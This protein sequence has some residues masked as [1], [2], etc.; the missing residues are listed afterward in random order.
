MSE[1]KASVLE[2]KEIKD[3]VPHPRQDKAPPQ[4]LIIKTKGLGLHKHDPSG[5]NGI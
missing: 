2:M 4:L 5:R 3:L 1:V